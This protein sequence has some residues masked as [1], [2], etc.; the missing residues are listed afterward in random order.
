MKKTSF[1]LFISLLMASNTYTAGMFMDEGH[2]HFTRLPSHNPFGFFMPG[3]G[4]GGSFQSPEEAA[5]QGRIHRA[6]TRGLQGTWKE[7][8]QEN[9]F[10][11][12]LMLIM[13]LKDL[14]NG[15]TWLSEKVFKKE[16]KS[17]SKPE[18]AFV[19]LN[20]AAKRAILN[21][22][23]IENASLAETLKKQQLENNQLGAE[24]I[25]KNRHLLNTIAGKQNVQS[26]LTQKQLEEA[27]FGLSQE[28]LMLCNPHLFEKMVEQ[29]V[30]AKVGAV[31][32]QLESQAQKQG[33]S[34]MSMLANGQGMSPQKTEKLAKP[35][36]APAA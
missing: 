28:A 8:L 16:E 14:K 5:R 9:L 24:A 2:P 23:Q 30:N 19:E 10:A 22:Q 18:M 1:L 12:P 33:F 34:L 26:D 27:A 3:M 29:A 35:I 32:Q 6:F 17:L 36:P 7:Q 31:L 13:V 21:K 4:E 15:L 20:L 25:E 11:N